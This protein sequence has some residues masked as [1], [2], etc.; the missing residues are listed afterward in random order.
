[1]W[2]S[3]EGPQSPLL[4]VPNLTAHPSTANVPNARRAGV[5]RAVPGRVV[6]RASY[7]RC[8]NGNVDAM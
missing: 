8:Y 2:Y 1:M 6:R 4:A 3:E 7:C 5:R